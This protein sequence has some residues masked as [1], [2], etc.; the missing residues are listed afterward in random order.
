MWAP[1]KGYHLAQLLGLVGPAGCMVAFEP[2]P[3]LAQAL[4]LRYAGNRRV[5]IDQTALGATR[6][7][8]TFHYVKNGPPYSGL[9]RRVYKIP[10]PI[11]EMINVEVDTLDSYAGFF[12]RV[13]FVKIDI[14]GGEI[15][16]LRGGL[17]FIAQHRPAFSVEYGSCSY[18]GYG[19]TAI[20]LYDLAQ[21]IGYV[22]VTVDGRQLDTPQRWL[23]VCD[24]DGWD[25]L[26]LPGEQLPP[27][28][29]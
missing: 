2:I 3:H 6:G 23:D 8:S 20:T 14:E 16:C 21:S 28:H 29:H 18:T 4:T 24:H 11:V 1:I 19:H 10:D 15:D 26:L 12:P 25:F 27:P 17:R 22:I 13:S 9:Q 5:G 7:T